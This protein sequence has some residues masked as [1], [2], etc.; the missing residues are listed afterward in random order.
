MSLQKHETFTFIIQEPVLHE[1]N[2]SP[3]QEKVAIMSTV[4]PTRD[5]QSELIGGQHLPDDQY[6]KV[7]QLRDMLDKVLMLDTTKRL[8]INQALTHPF[9]T[10][11]I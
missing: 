2:V 1:K 11:K 3:T 5:L 4:S 7:V 6:R 9:V 10:E 8:T